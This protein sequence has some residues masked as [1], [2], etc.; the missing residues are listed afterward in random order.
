[1]SIVD[2]RERAYALR[3][4]VGITARQDVYGGFISARNTLERLQEALAEA[5]ESPYE[6]PLVDQLRDEL[7]VA[8]GA[9]ETAVRRLG[10]AKVTVNK[11]VH[12]PI[13]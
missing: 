8:V 3:R 11:L 1:M 13:P 9:L 7:N 6:D 2:D 4:E 5:V 12:Y 10:E